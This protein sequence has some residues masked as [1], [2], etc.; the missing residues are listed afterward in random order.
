[1]RAL[2]DTHVLLWLRSGDERLPQRWRKVLLGR[3]DQLHFSAASAAEISIKF[4]SGKLK[5]P[6]PPKEF[7]PFMISD[8][9]LRTLPI[10][11]QDTLTVSTLPLHHG[12]PFDR[13]LVA[14]AMSE[15][16]PLI[17]ADPHMSRYDIQILW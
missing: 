5:L 3:A 10:S 6:Q 9:R 1:M 2:L 4:A 13:L 17:T 11:L 8:L 16:L 7:V 12:D 15:S 14:Q